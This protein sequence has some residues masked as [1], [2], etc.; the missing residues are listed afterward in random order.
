[1]RLAAAL[2]HTECLLDLLAAGADP[3]RQR[4]GALYDAVVYGKPDRAAA[5]LAAGADPAAQ[6]CA[7]A[8]FSA[9]SGDTEALRA[10]LATGVDPNGP[11]FDDDCFLA[12]AA[13]DENFAC[14]LRC[15][16]PHATAR[17]VASR[18]CL[19]PAPIPMPRPAA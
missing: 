14:F 10:Y 16:R 15:A 5:L 9:R 11:G 17:S 12:G 8:K 18:P 3:R 2:G 4:S 1:L 13:K 7:A 6:A 19:R